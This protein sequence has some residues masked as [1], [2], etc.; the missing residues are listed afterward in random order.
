[1]NKGTTR[2]KAD[3]SFQ[4]LM[5]LRLPRIAELLA[6]HGFSEATR[7]E[8]V[9]LVEAFLSSRADEILVAPR[10][11]RDAVA[12]AF[13]KQWYPIARSSLERTYPAVGTQLLGNLRRAKDRQMAFLGVTIFGE[14]YVAL[15]QGR[16]PKSATV[17]AAVLAE[18]PAAFALLSE[19]GLTA[20]VVADML[21]FMQDSMGLTDDQITAYHS[22][23]RALSQEQAALDAL[24]AWYL[25]W[26]AVARTVIKNRTHLRALGFLRK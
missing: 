21:R 1:M 23:Q 15:A 19:R 14:R 4:L 6:P 9:R 17:S 22:Q 24:W 12:Q 2:Q 25:E 8:G 5:G 16:S 26:S 18:V 3:A 10:P 7:A 11:N 13:E 20:D